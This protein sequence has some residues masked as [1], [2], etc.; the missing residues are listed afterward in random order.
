[1]H[2]T[3]TERTIVDALSDG[4]P[5]TIEAL[6]PLLD[7]GMASRGAVAV[8]I[9]NIRRKLPP[10]QAILWDGPVGAY[11]LVRLLASPYN[12]SN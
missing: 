9:Y 7:D 12:G 1:M 11:R 2:L 8:H 5:R 4:T 3:K 6:L 10:G